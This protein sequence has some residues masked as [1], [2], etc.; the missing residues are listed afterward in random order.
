M[1]NNRYDTVALKLNLQS[2]LTPQT[3]SPSSQNVFYLNPGGMSGVPNEMW[4]LL[5]SLY[6]AEENDADND[7]PIEQNH[8]DDQSPV[9]VGMEECELL[10]SYVQSKLNKLQST[11][12]RF[13][14]L[15]PFLSFF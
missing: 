11:Q 8:P 12:Q 6:Q 9:E 15:F 1:N 4:H 14:P 5:S 7:T 13:S 10:Y 2:S 3:T